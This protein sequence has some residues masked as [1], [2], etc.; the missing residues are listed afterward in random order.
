MDKMGKGKRKFEGKRKRYKL[1]REEMDIT[2]ELRIVG[3]LPQIKILYVGIY[4]YCNY[5]S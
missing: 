3:L 1:C 2:E 4:M 5:Y